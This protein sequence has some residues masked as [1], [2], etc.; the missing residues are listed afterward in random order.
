MHISAFSSA[1][2][3][4]LISNAVY[5][6]WSELSVCPGS[7]AY[8]GFVIFVLIRS[9]GEGLNKAGIECDCKCLSSNHLQNR[10]D[11]THHQ[12]FLFYWKL[13]NH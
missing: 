1:N 11:K 3:L 12:F 7:T 8:A 5:P 9:K 13:A 10:T 2:I 4:L 6:I